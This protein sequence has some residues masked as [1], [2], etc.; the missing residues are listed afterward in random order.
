MFDYQDKTVVIT[1][2]TGGLGSELCWEFLR[3]GARLAM[4]SRSEER[5]QHLHE[6]ILS[7]GGKSI[8]R[9]ANVSN[10]EEVKKFIQYVLQEYKSFDV[11]INNAGITTNIDFLKITNEMVEEEIKVNY[12]GAVYLMKEIIPFFLK[13]NEGQIIN[14]S[15][16]LAFRPF[17]FLASYSASKAAMSAF[18]DSL[19]IEL[20]GTDIDV[21]N[22][23]PGKLNTSFS[24]NPQMSRKAKYKNIVGKG[25]NPENAAKIIVAAASRKK[26]N[27]H[28]HISG[29]II[30]WC[31]PLLGPIF[32]KILYHAKVK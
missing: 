5:L 14:I 12:L 28:T 31:N 27:I 21:I 16:I 9:A 25:M 26:R 18:T 3:Q 20:R 29:Q 4:C 32:E 2:A 6:K 30:F 7:F 11:L 22:V 19:R 24:N 23:Y 17:P 13:K 8:Y 1:G 10:P 15:S